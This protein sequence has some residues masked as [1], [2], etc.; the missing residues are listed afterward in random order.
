MENPHKVLDSME[1]ILSDSRSWDR[2]GQLAAFAALKTL[3]S[4]LEVYVEEYKVPGYGYIHEKLAGLHFHI[5]ALYGVDEDNG[6]DS[7]SHHVWALGDIGTVRRNIPQ[8]E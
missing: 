8:R 4:E 3:I 1:R 6:H 7:Q 5:G 2:V